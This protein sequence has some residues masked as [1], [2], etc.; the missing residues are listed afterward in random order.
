MKRKIKLK[1][2]ILGFVIC[3]I[4]FISFICSI[5]AT[6]I[7]QENK[8]YHFINDNKNFQIQILNENL[9]NKGK[10]CFGYQV[11]PNPDII[12]NFD[13]DKPGNLNKIGTPISSDKIAGGTWVNGVWWCCEY[14][15]VSNSNIWIIDH[16]TGDMTLVGESG[17][18]E[19]LHGLAY[20]DLTDTMYACGAT[21]LFTINMTTGAATIVGSFG[22]SGSVMI[23]IACDGY[24]NMYGE[25]LH[26]DSLYSINLKT[27][28]ATLIGK[29]G[30]DL[31]YGQ[32]M[33]FD[34]ESGICYLSAFTVHEGNE[35]AL[36]TCNLTSGATTKIGN[37]GSEPTQITGF[38]IPYNLNN[39]PSTPTIDGPRSGKVG[40]LYNYD[41]FSTD[42]DGDNI[43]YHIC[44]GDN[45]IIYIYGPY[46][47]G[48]KITLSYN[49]SEKG[50]YIITCWARD[51]HDQISKNATLEVNIPKNKV[52]KNLYIIKL[53]INY[54]FWNDCH[55]YYIL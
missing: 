46:N 34:K 49:W 24:G 27:G 15:P 51:E 16:I 2:K 5:S 55:P 43:W 33:A 29:F 36:Y 28:S 19:G 52:M 39:P 40:E 38:V 44:W 12:V 11:Y 25:D 1:N 48:E 37:F 41:F 17:S 26:T 14:T 13:I 32:D 23:G 21:N 20:D 8:D 6:E 10:T 50:S 22:I 42:S 45:E 53:L 3:S 31:N 18:S 47:S 4:F 35:G 9:I 30:L 7:S 54:I